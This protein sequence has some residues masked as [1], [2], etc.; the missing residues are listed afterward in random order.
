LKESKLPTVIIPIHNARRELEACLDS[1]HRHTPVQSEVLLL[2]DASD[3][4]QVQ[5]LLR[6]WLG[7][8]GPSWSLE[9]LPH[10]RGFVDTVNMGMKM[11][12]GNVVLLNSDTIVTPGWLEGLQRCLASDSRI[13]TATPWTNNGEIASIPEFCHASPVPADADAIAAVIA[14]AGRPAY[15]E[16]PTA[17]GFCMAI[18]RAA[19]DA[20]GLFD[21]ALFGLG[22][23]E[24]NDFSMRARRAGMRNVLCDDVYVAHVGGRS[25]APRNI[26][27]DEAAMKKLLSRHPGY[28]QLIRQFISADPLASR[29]NELLAAL[30]NAGI[31]IG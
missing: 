24:E 28:L 22:Y 30:R 13:A 31:E 17:V 16:I 8:A 29:R 14:A 11:T 25:F 26:R 21:Q 9:L 18:S 1:L 12:R 6:R 10:N 7:R 19:I 2:D 23:G 4:P 15:P 3:D 5:P 27:P 20:L